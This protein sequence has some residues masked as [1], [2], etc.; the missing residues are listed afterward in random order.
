MVTNARFVALKTCSMVALAVAVSACGKSASLR[1]ESPNAQGGQKQTQD[2]TTPPVVQVPTTTPPVDSTPTEQP[3][4]VAESTTSAGSAGSTSSVPA[5]QSKT[6]PPVVAQKPV[7]HC[8]QDANY[9]FPLDNRYHVVREGGYFTAYVTEIDSWGYADFTNLYAAFGTWAGMRFNGGYIQN[10]RYVA[11][12]Y[13]FHIV[14]SGAGLVGIVSSDNAADRVV[15]VVET[16]LRSDL[17]ASRTPQQ[18]KIRLNPDVC[19]VQYG[20]S[21][22]ALVSAGAGWLLLQ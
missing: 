2:T 16:T 8:Y 1:G 5:G 9:K 7:S 15:G 11:A 19:L 14:R 17:L 13:V 12:D 18:V 21:S 10:G 4:V 3:P 20:D 22:G 6:T